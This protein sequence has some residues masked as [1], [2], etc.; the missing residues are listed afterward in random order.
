MKQLT[1]RG[2]T[3]IDWQALANEAQN[4]LKNISLEVISQ[5][6]SNLFTKGYLMGFPQIGKIALTEHYKAEK[7]IFDFIT[8]ENEK[9]QNQKIMDMFTSRVF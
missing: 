2:D 7:K 1:E 8:S 6:T 4:T 5:T 9:T 3:L